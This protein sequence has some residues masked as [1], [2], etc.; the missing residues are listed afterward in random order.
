MTLDNKEDGRRPASDAELHI[1]QAAVLWAQAREATSSET[2]A[3]F[4]RLA[5]LYERLAV[6]AARREPKSL[7]LEELLYPDK[8]KCHLTERDWVTLL[9]GVARRDHDALQTLYLST[10]R[11]VFTLI[12]QITHERLAAEDLTVEVFHDLWQGADRYDPAAGTVIGWIMSQARSRA[13]SRLRFEQRGYGSSPHAETR[14]DGAPVLEPTRASPSELARSS[15][16]LWRRLAERLSSE[17]ALRPLPTV[18]AIDAEVHWEQPAPGL[19]CKLLAT[20][21]E[22]SRLCA[23]V[24]LA[25]GAEYPPHTHAG[26]EELHLLQGELWIDDRKLHPGDYNRAERGTAD[27]RV[28]SETG[29]TC[30]LITSSRDIIRRLA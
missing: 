28:W 20:D 2:R 24:R 11:L 3:E 16:S 4:E 30:V 5:L 7:T 9:T 6:R 27:K 26:V 12:M 14:A 15:A 10:H 19:W 17:D 25:P 18:A 13:L 1:Q 29:C 8:T 21:T 22:H 23:L